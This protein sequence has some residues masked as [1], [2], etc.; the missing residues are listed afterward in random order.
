MITRWIEARKSNATLVSDIDNGRYMLSMQF[1]SGFT[2]AWL[3]YIVS[4]GFWLS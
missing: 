2:V 1:S 4:Y 3:I